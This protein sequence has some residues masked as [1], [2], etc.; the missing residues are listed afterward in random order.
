MIKV[1]WCLVLSVLA[2]S[3]DTSDE[4]RRDIIDNMI[5][6]SSQDIYCTLEILMIFV[7][8]RCLLDLEMVVL[9]SFNYGEQI[10]V[11][12]RNRPNREILL[13]DWLITSHVI[14]ITS[15]DWLFT[16]SVAG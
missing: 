2:K 11:Y 6:I 16:W 7:V 4:H 14:Q 8:W 10:R 13:S 3:H 12:F 5:Y 9:F 1:H 15:S